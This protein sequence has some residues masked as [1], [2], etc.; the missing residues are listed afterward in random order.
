VLQRLE[1]CVLAVR[2]QDVDLR[3]LTRALQDASGA[4]TMAK[5]FPDLIEQWR[6]RRSYTRKQMSE[7]VSFFVT[8][9]RPTLVPL[10]QTLR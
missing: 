2:L 5:S 9:T 7:S 6:E 8:S 4:V 1:S 3:E 10:A